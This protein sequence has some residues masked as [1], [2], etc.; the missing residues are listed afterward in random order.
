M[1]KITLIVVSVMLLLTAVLCGCQSI[2]PPTYAQ[3]TT[4]A[5]LQALN[6]GDYQ[7]Y[8]SYLTD[9]AKSELSESAFG[10]Y[11]GYCDEIIG[12]YQS[13]EL[14]DV[15]VKSG[16]TTV[17]YNAKYTLVDDVLVTMVFSE[18]GT[19]SFVDS[20]TI[21]S[22]E[23]E[24]LHAQ[25]VTRAMLQAINSGDFTTYCYFMTQDMLMRTSQDI[26]NSL[27]SFYANRIGYYVSSTLTSVRIASA[28]VVLVFDA[29]Y[30]KADDVIVTAT[31]I[32]ISDVVLIDD[33][34]LNC[35]ELWQQ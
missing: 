2:T 30:T 20:L 12:Q 23:L 14:N 22:M 28:K 4:E 1:R 13:L 35:P 10:I 18:N 5:M 21:S 8:V 32:A 9:N 7:Q 34:F 26:F 3:S 11:K 33:I 25:E 27:K 6:S 29:T 15:T 19:Q 24:P 17:V 16:L 31:F